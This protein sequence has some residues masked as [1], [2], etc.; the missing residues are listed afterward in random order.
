MG[1][2]LLA[3]DPGKEKV[4]VAVLKGDGSIAFKAV[5]PITSLEGVLSELRDRYAFSEAV[6]GESTGK[7]GMAALLERIGIEIRWVDEW[8]SSEEAW[9]VYLRECCTGRWQRLKAL[10]SLL[11]SSR[12]YDDWQAVV[13][14]RR[15][16]HK[17][18][19]L[20]GKREEVR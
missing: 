7:A 15:F 2:F 9:R 17:R 13:L 4:G 8:R 3:L 19:E 11:F 1:D 12:A 10:F 16:L 14:G 6:V 20:H 5:L 18:D